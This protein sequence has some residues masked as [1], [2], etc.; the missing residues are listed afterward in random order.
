M[1]LGS[2][3]DAFTVPVPVTVLVDDDTPKPV[4]FAELLYGELGAGRPPLVGLAIS[5]LDVGGFCRA[6][7]PNDGRQGA[8]TVRPD[9]LVLGE[10]G[11]PV[12]CL[13]CP[14]A[15][16]KPTARNKRTE[17]TNRNGKLLGRM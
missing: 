14:I 15:G 3:A 9:V 5:P 6:R 10:P 13:D 12:V 4:P 17:V 16:I 1:E 2:L 11:T 8:G 7:P